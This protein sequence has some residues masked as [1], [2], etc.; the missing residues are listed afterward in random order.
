MVDHS[1]KEPLRISADLKVVPLTQQQG[2]FSLLIDY[3]AGPLLE[4]NPNDEVVQG[5][6]P[7][8]ATQRDFGGCI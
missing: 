3:C 4:S 2:D 1:D 6:R 8:R 7:R 5:Y